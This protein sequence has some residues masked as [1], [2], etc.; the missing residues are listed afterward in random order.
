MMTH[1]LL[2]D[3]MTATDTT[4]AGSI[5][6]LYDELL[7]PLF[8][9]PYA[10]DIAERLRDVS[11]GAV[12]ETAAGT[13]VL[14]RALARSLP[15]H[16]RIA[17][18]DLNEGMLSVAARS[19]TR[20]VTFQTA[21]AQKLPFADGEFDAVLCQFGIMFLPDKVAGFREARRVL[22]PTG[23]FVFNVWAELEKNEVTLVACRAVASLFPDDPPRFFERVPF[24]YHDE[25]TIRRDLESAGFARVEI[26]VVEKCTRA[27]SPAALA[28]GMC[29]GT[30]LRNEIEARAAHRLDEVTSKATEA[31]AAR[32]GSG[33]FDN[34]MRA[35]VVTAFAS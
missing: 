6:A 30:P 1:L 34:P 19:T 18:T 14:T 23:R 22:S 20:P 28:E 4:F 10:E 9:E 11:V 25:E 5:P 2:E 17:S 32:F 16:V 3:V 35:L 27:P 29:K 21:D 26:E 12:L 13:G 7:V 8:F 24:G 15:P 31:L 33:P